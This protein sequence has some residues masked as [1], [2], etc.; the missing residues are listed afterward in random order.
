MR[1]PWQGFTYLL[2][3]ERASSSRSCASSRRA[4]YLLSLDILYQNFYKLL[5]LKFFY[6]IS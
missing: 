5:Q 6:R 3:A 4:E 2:K 1:S